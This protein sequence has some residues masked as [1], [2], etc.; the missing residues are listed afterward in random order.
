MRHGRLLAPLALL[1]AAAVPALAEEQPPCARLDHLVGFLARS[2]G[3][4]PVSAG[5]QGNGQLLEIFASGDTGT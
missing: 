4:K 3:E 1:A 2:Y 5:L